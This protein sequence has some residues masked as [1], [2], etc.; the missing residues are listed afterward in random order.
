MQSPEAPAQKVNH[1]VA[2]DAPKDQR[3]LAGIR[4]IVDCVSMKN[5]LT[6]L[7]TGSLLLSLVALAG[8]G[9][10]AP[11]PAVK[12][13]AADVEWPMHGLDAAETRYSALTQVSEETV[14]ELGVAWTY[15]L[16]SD[17]GVETTPIVVDGVMYATAP[18][19]VVHAIDP[20][21][22]KGLW[23]F[24]PKVP[25][26]WG[27]WACC[28]VVNRGV[29]VSAESVLTATLDGRLIALNKTTG[30]LIWEV[31]TTPRDKAYTIT[32]APRIANGKVIIGNGG[33]EYGVRGY[34][35]AY[36]VKTGEQLWRFYTVPGDPVNPQEHP[37][38][39]IALPTWTGEW[40]KAGGGGTAWDSMAFDPEL[41]LLY[42]GIGNGSPWSRFERS[43]GGG[44][45]LFL[46][47]ILA[48]DVDT[49]R[50]KWHYQTTPNDSWDYTATQHM[51]LTDIAINGE[52]RKVLLQAP[53]NGF[54]YA[55]DRVTGELLSATNYV[56]VNWATHVDIE[57]GRPVQTA[58]GNYG[59][60]LKKVIP[61][62]QGGHNWQPM[63]FSK[64]TGLLYLPAH[65]TGLW[66]KNDE[67][68]EYD[69][70]S[71]NVGVMLDA[72]FVENTIRDA[73][74]FRGHLIAWDPIKREPR[75]Q[76]RFEGHWNGGVLS[77]AGGLVFQGTADGNFTAYRDT[78]G[79]QLW[80]SKSTTGF[81]APPITYRS[82]GEQYV[83]IAAGIGGGGMAA[84]VPGAAINTYLNEGRIIAYKLGGAAPMPVSA[85]RDL[86]VPPAPNIQTTAAQVAA[87]AESY[88]KYCG[89]CHGLFVQ[90]SLL[91][92]DLRHLTPEK[93]AIFQQIV[94]GGAYVG[95]GMPKF[96]DALTPEDVTNI[97]AYILEAAKPLRALA[98]EA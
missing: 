2:L 64:N 19:S 33:G 4:I 24:D 86:R 84:P 31:Q 1:S 67:A 28:D 62:P 98:P 89:W 71:W 35:T 70:S 3:Y 56:N 83:A 50:L 94:L 58:A 53:K 77:T 96:D 20:T 15:E 23:Q 74:P 48:V 81:F 55:L 29:A 27:R 66:F 78:D 41:N 57:T 91:F 39:E 52:L 80:Q 9:P 65:D 25:K 10:D 54:L 59:E 17:R 76:K 72:E 38:L 88:D 34:F 32:G 95:L 12:A 51:I 6:R 45:N 14:S 18:W 40:W 61:G 75:W 93:H 63:S 49:G 43:P 47:S 16:G 36:D 37:D 21:T 87:G 8:C 46:S 60:K 79:E 42:V 13:V 92:P 7:T 90:S 97:Q 5:T 44:D 26:Q 30:K 82:N 11:A 85:T 73:P 68:F 69:P 22:G